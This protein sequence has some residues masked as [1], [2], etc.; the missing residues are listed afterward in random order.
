MKQSEEVKQIRQR[1]QNG[2]HITED[3]RQA[4]I[5]EIIANFE[6]LGLVRKEESTESAQNAL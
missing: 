5:R 4:M 3:E 6:R 1:I 2:E